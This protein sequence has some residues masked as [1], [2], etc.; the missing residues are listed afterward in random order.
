LFF[1]ILRSSADHNIAF[2]VIDARL[3]L[4][5]PPGKHQRSRKR[6]NSPDIHCYD[7]QY[8][9][10]HIELRRTKRRNAHRTHCRRTFKQN[11]RQRKTDRKKMLNE[12]FGLEILADATLIQWDG[13]DACLLT[14][15]EIP[16]EE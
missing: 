1:H 13:E 6:A 11:I 15:R 16:K 10:N 5:L 14:C 8:A 7:N 4:S 12:Q 3:F 9:R 2:R